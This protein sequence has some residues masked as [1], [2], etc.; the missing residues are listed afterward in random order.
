[1]KCQRWVF[2]THSLEGNSLYVMHV[3]GLLESQKNC[4][5]DRV[6]PLT[7]LLK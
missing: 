4:E 1:M 2:L 3:L 6:G 7:L 5:A